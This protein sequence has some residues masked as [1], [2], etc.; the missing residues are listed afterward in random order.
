LSRINKHRYSTKQVFTRF[1]ASVAIVFSLVVVIFITVA[2]MRYFN[3]LADF[4]KSSSELL[5]QQ[6]SLLTKQ[7]TNNV[8]TLK[9]LEEF[10]NY[11]INN[12]QQI[13][14]AN[15]PLAQQDNLFYLDIPSRD[16]FNQRKQISANI[17]GIG[18]IS[19]FDE[20][21]KQEISMAY[22]L[23]PAFVVAQ[24]AN[25]IDTWFYYVSVNKFVSLYPWIGRQSWH[26]SNKMNSHKFINL[27]KESSVK[28]NIFW[29]P[30]FQDTAGKGLMAS[31]SAGVFRQKQFIGAIVIDINLALLRDSFVDLLSENQGFVLLDNNKHVLVEHSVNSRVISMT[32][33]LADVLPKSLSNLSLEALEG[34]K[35]NFKIGDWLVS[36]KV[37]PIN[38]WTLVQYQHYDDFITPLFHEFSS[39]FLLLFIGLVAFLVFIYWLTRTTF[40]KP[41]TEFI[42]HIE[43]CAEGDPGKI[44]PNN[45]WLHWF[46]IVEDIF[47]QN[48]SLLQQLKDQNSQL[49]T[50]V[51]EKTYELQQSN[52]K[53]QR[54]YALLR[55]VMNAIPELIVFSD[56]EG[57]LIGCNSELERYL[58]KTEQQMFGCIVAELMPERLSRALQ[59][60]SARAFLDEKAKAYQSVVWDHE[61][62][63]ELYSRK[64]FN[65][66]KVA[67]GTINIFRDVTEQYETQAALELAKNQAEN[68][69]KAK[70]QFLANM[71]HEIR[72]PIN[73][74]QGMMYLLEKTN[75][76]TVQLQYLHNAETASKSLMYL[77]DEL[78]DLSRIESGKISLSKS[79]V[80]L[81]DVVDKALKLNIGVANKKQLPIEVVVDA[82]VPHMFI[83]DEIRLVQVI[84]NLLN[85][86]VKFTAQ[87]KV[88]LTI[89]C[90]ALN[91]N[92]GNALVKFSVRDTGIGIEKDKQAKLF[93]AFTQA[94]E[95]MTRK[96]GGS[97]L[98]L[99]ICKQ[100]V[101]MFGGDITLKSELNEG[102][103]F[104]FVLPLSHSKSWSQQLELQQDNIQRVSVYSLG[105][106]LPE[107]V[108]NTLT[109]QKWF[110]HQL[111]ASSD[112]PQIDAKKPAI[113]LLDIKELAKDLSFFSSE[114][115]A[116]LKQRFNYFGL[117]QAMMSEVNSE[118]C[119]IF[120]QQN[121][122]WF[123][124]EQPIYRA[125]AK[126]MFHFVKQKSVDI[127][128]QLTTSA[129]VKTEQTGNLLGKKILLVE[130]NLVNQL[131][132][133]ELLLSMKA[134]VL[135]AD[136][137]QKAIDILQQNKVDAV[138]MDIQMPVM[139]GLTAATEIRKLSQ[140]ATL[141]IIAMTAHAREHDQ[142]QSIAAGM[143]KHISKP[144]SYNVLLNTLL[145]VL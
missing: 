119:N 31:L 73:A 128:H 54:D 66:Q 104:S 97:G 39:L 16:I 123:I 101:N 93:E 142:Q 134:E 112:L 92:E 111:Q 87:G 34:S 3:E 28:G 125:L 9:G 65:D 42:Q 57:K 105:V 98:G 81:D 78:L 5:T 23:T 48:R 37:L 91:E 40:I 15:V 36:K 122:A 138:L 106:N 131:V 143:N 71:S 62:T 60:L 107:A 2:T 120:E 22:S 20:Q 64:F 47:S 1:N 113:L 79:T 61:K 124:V 70:S 13:K 18:D 59:Q 133:K 86:A 84:A 103:E 96:Y 137:G 24:H 77:I 58:A 68:A 33:Q 17:T 135:I 109:M 115:W 44:K 76:N 7:L 6:A 88:S 136:N 21:M 4:E 80:V 10:A 141:P 100:I 19:S 8:N 83:S 25:P 74:V 27:V 116:K 132:A 41:A 114:Q 46:K 53:H 129:E 63:F 99:S 49:D 110:Y 118:V 51:N 90:T 14:S 82:D 94:D 140:F 45:D 11:A 144:V 43:Y 127:S 52:L 29:T 35:Q 56:P 75:L 67:L 130:D 139:D 50:R 72:T 145:S 117:S 121:L 102:S 55:S 126:N 89:S 12:P 30:A 69:S 108:V 85:N 32:T 26:Y 95:S 38:G